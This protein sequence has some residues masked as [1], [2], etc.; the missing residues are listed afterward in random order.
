MSDAAI[1]TL[2]QVQDIVHQEAMAA[3]KEYLNRLI[4]NKIAR[5]FRRK[6]N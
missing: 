1:L 6:K 5:L 3:F 2:E 4:R